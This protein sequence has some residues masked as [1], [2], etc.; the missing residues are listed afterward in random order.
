M[1]MIRLHDDLE[2]EPSSPLHKPLLVGGG[3]EHYVYR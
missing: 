2:P 3:I 1:E